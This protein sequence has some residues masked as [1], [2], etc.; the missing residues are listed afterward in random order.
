MASEHLRA[1]ALDPRITFLN[2]GA[3]GA[4]PRAVLEHQHE[5][6]LRIEAN[7]VQFLARELPSRIDAA[8][9]QIAEFVGSDAEDLVFVRS[10]TEAIATVLASVQVAP[11]DELLTTDHAYPACRR[12]LELA[13]ARH[14]AEVR[15]ARL[16]SVIRDPA[17][18]VTSIV[19]AANERTRLAVIDHITSATGLVFPIAN[20]V[21]EL[22]ARGIDT[23]VDGAHAPGSIHLDVNAIDAAYYAGSLHKWTG[24]PKGVAILHVRRDRQ[25]R[26]LPLAISHGASPGSVRP[27]L[28]DEFDWTGTSDPTPWLCAPVALRTMAALVAGGMPSVIDRNRALAIR[29]RRSLCAELGIDPPSPESMIAAL[30]ALPLSADPRALATAPDPLR[31]ALLARH[32]IEVAMFPWPSAAERAL[33]IA[34]PIYVDD[35]DVSRLVLALHAELASA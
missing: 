19:A 12:A 22:S 30:V 8:R 9:E 13:A 33:R 28:W 32:G 23:L 10:T 11:G 15:I 34:C 29:A 7:P 1:F 2:H 20:I 26:I 6:R 24:A 3:F 21:A 17:E 4:C 5:L 18:V 27:R 35:A 16:P 31:T 25:P 14:R